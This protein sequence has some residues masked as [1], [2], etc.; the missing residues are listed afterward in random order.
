MIVLVKRYKT[1]LVLLVLL[2]AFIVLF[3]NPL[4]RSESYIAEYILDITPLGT[5]FDDVL[6]SVNTK[7]WELNFA[8]ESSG[9]YHQGVT[10]NEI[11]GEKS[12]RASLGDYQGFPLQTNVTVFW[13]F[14]SKG[15]L[16]DIWVWKTRDGL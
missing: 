12:I 6:N 15:E 4:R 10:P 2:I 1:F 5:S 14:N 11:V 7:K 3:S 16:I 8:N 9:F 13:G